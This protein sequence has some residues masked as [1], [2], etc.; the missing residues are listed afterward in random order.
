MAGAGVGDGAA[1]G[2]GQRFAYR[3]RRREVERASGSAVGPHPIAAHWAGPEAFALASSKAG[4]R[5]TAETAG[6]TATS[7]FHG[8]GSTSGG[9]GE[10]CT[11]WG[12]GRLH[13]TQSAVL[14]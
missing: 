6:Q 3:G 13:G 9:L 2:G 12:S 10:E 5:S 11:G 8:G 7:R 4:G 1:V 14:Q